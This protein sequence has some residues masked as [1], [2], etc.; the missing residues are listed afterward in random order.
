MCVVQ[1]FL[2][3]LCV[4]ILQTARTKCVIASPDYF[5]DRVKKVGQVGLSLSGR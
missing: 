5:P 4:P 1:E 2:A 3:V